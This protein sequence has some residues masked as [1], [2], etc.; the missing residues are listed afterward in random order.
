MRL[1][2]VGLAL[3]L[4]LVPWPPA[5]SQGPGTAVATDA[6]DDVRAEVQTTPT[7]TPGGSH[8]SMDLVALAVAEDKEA[9]TFTV[10][11]ADLK[12]SSE[13]TAL[14]G[15]RFELLFSHNGR[16]FRLEFDQVLPTLGL[17]WLARLD[18][19]DD[20]AGDWTQVWSSD[21]AVVADAAADTLTVALDRDLLADRDGAAPFPSRTL[22]GLRMASRAFLS[23]IAVF[24]GTPAQIQAPVRVVDEMPDAGQPT[25]SYAIQVGLVQSG[26]ARLTS[27]V[28][29]RASNG[30]AT[31]FLLNATAR[32]LADR[33]DRFSF[34]A[35]GVPGRLAVT[36]PVSTATVAA[37]GAVDIPVLVTVPFAHIHGGVDDFTL[38]MHSASDPGSVGRIAMGLRYLAVPQPAGHHDT[39]YLHSREVLLVAGALSRAE[40]YMNTLEADGIDTAQP[41]AAYGLSINGGNVTHT[42]AIGLEPGLEM[43][44][45]FD[46]SR[47]GTLSLPVGTPALPLAQATLTA[48]LATGRSSYYSDDGQVLARM[49]PAGPV[50]ILPQSPHLFTGELVADPEADRLPFEPG[51]NLVLF[52]ALTTATPS[53]IGEET[54]RIHPGGHFTLPLL[55]YHD[56]VD[57]ALQALDGPALSPLG[58]QERLMNPGEAVVFPFSLANPA[59]E[60]RAYHVEVSGANMEWGTIPSNHVTVPA[61]GVA[62]GSLIVRAPAGAGDGDRADLILQAYDVS[63][64]TARGLL[65]LLAEVDTA[66]DHPDDTAV[67]ADLEK[68]KDSPAGSALAALGLLALVAAARRRR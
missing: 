68:T 37:G 23:D 9:V 22:D 2:A 40:G 66:A 29:Y 30:E 33:E 62:T 51:R 46:L 55:E 35:V 53:F 16:E 10:A 43:G 8:S 67:A 54:P 4:L 44:L 26:H 63:D 11:V 18:S 39:L 57:D 17:R 42:W 56:P 31:T 24:P 32:N 34:S 5:A 36:L 6:T 47:L 1:L 7:A 52:V 59:G 60:E 19:R 41:V 21:A 58:A 65:R 61:N 45:D 15:I 12:P 38:E 14:D 13:E 49:A 20:P 3:L 28:P 48:E 27:S 50:D 64:P 25:V